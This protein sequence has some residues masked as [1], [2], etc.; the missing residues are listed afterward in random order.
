[1]NTK[2]DFQAIKIFKKTLLWKLFKDFVRTS[3]SF[4]FKEIVYR[5]ICNKLLFL[6]TIVTYFDFLSRVIFLFGEMKF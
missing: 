1:M 3:G 6:K 5:K 4:Y 2:G